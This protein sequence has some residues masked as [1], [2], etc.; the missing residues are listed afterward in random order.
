MAIDLWQCNSTG[1]YS[2]VDAPGQAGEG[3]T[4]LR[5]V[6]MSDREGVASF[7]TVFPG[8]YAGRTNHIHV[9]ATRDPRVLDASQQYEGGVPTH[10][11][12]FYFDERLIELVEAVQPYAGNDKP[13]VRNDRDGI[14]VAA[15]TDENDIFMDYV[16]LGDGVGYGI[17]AWITVGVDMRA[18]QSDSLAVAATATPALS[19]SGSP[20]SGSSSSTQGSTIVTTTPTGG[21]LRAVA[22]PF[23]LGWR[24]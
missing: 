23:L 11:G 24:L 10:I 8:H 9:M 12:Q 22:T 4:W 15:A 7:D 20:G 2:G 16:L 5:G 21:A 19:T 18:D 6:Q 17:L 14:A 3:T 1:V 13:R